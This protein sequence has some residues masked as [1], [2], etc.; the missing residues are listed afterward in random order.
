MNALV[1]GSGAREHALAWKL[2]RSPLV[3]RLYCAPGN[4]GTAAIAE[5]VPLA[6][7]DVAGLAAWAEAHRIDLTV[8][9]PEDAL[10]A[11][12][13]DA[14]AARG[15]TVFGPSAAGARIE[16]SKSWAKELMARMRIPTARTAAFDDADAARAYVRSQPAP[17]VVKADG[18]AAGK[19]VLMCPTTDDALAAIAE[20]MERG[21]FGAAGRRIVVEECLTGPEVSLL[22]LVDG[23]RA[24]PLIPACDYKRVFD[25]DGGPNTGGMGSYAP[26]RFVSPD[27]HAEIVRT[28]VEPTVRGFREAGIDYRGILYVGLM[29]TPA[30]PKVLEY[31]ARFGDPETQ[32][33]LPLLDSDLVEVALATANGRLD[34]ALVRWK[35]GA[36][37][38]VVLASG[39]YPG[40]YE[41]GKVIAGLDRLDPDVPAFHAGT[42]RVDGRLVT[43]GG[44]VLTVVAT[45]RDMA[46][47]RARA[48]D[49]VARV[50]FEGMHYRRDIALREVI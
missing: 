45:G 26:P 43:A 16:G 31:N 49:N 21:T 5:N 40:R 4:A 6:A 39:G 19:G 34:P 36:A 37:C 20:C 23:E 27:L 47:A 44:R 2:S 28:I 48:Y 14:L 32:A 24:V 13:A 29:L 46:E 7:T 15:L 10:V 25:G 42:K 38:G 3:T 18:L 12:L 1:V 8:V 30:G 17:L 35:P 41:V 33:V 11:G 22:A 9:G 50:S